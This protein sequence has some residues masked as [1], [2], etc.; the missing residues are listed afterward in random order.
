MLTARARPAQQ[1]RMGASSLIKRH[2]LRTTAAG[3]GLTIAY[4]RR[5]LAALCVVDTL[6]D[7]LL[8]EAA[9]RHVMR[10]FATVC[11]HSRHR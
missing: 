8:D 9:E 2:G 5:V 10:Q 7:T 3:C 6:V 11:L 4:L 1:S